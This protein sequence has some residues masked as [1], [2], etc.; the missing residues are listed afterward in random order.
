MSEPTPGEAVR[1]FYRK[2]GEARQLLKI[3]TLL[4]AMKA[5]GPF[6]VLSIDEVLAIINEA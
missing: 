1:E 4:N 2:Q 6:I 3:Q 5:T